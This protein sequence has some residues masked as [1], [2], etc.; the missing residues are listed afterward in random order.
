[1][2]KFD[3]H[4]IFFGQKS[5]LTNYQVRVYG[6]PRIRAISTPDADVE[7]VRTALTVGLHQAFDPISR[8]FHKVNIFIPPARRD[9]VVGQ[10]RVMASDLTKRIR[11]DQAASPE[12]KAQGTK[13]LRILK[14]WIGSL[15][16]PTNEGTPWPSI[17]PDYWAAF[18]YTDKDTVPSWVKIA[19]G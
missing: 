5:D 14:E 2:H 9:W 3:I 4:R 15:Q 8:D 18:G 6:S 16:F 17:A 19:L 1:M 11:S 7:R 13:V 12:A 10:V